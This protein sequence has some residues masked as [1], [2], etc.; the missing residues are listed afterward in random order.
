M[1][2]RD[3]R[4]ECIWKRANVLSGIHECAAYW[5]DRLV[6]VQVAVSM[7]GPSAG[8]C[9]NAQYRFKRSE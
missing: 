7:A 6:D 1:D 5:S 4:D 2:G 8:V 3:G 9:R